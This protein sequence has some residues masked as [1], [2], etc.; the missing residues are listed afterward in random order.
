MTKPIK[1]TA[2]STCDLSAPLLRK[3][4]ISIAPLHI[5][6]G[7]RTYRD[8]VD[9]VPGDLY[10][11]VKGTG[12]LPKTSA[13]TVAD[14]LD[15]FRPFTES[16][17]A[18]IHFTISRTMSSCYQNAVLAGRETGNVFV[19]DS[20]NL[21]TGIG[22]LALRAA[23]LARTG[24]GAEAIVRAA[25]RLIPKVESSFIIDT[26]RYLYKGGRCSSVAA[27]GANLLSLKP[28]I[29]VRG[30][31]MAVGKKYR[32]SLEKCLVSYVTDRLKGRADLDLSRIFITHSAMPDGLCEKAARL[33]KTLAPFREVLDTSAGGTI[34]SHCGPG[35]LGVLFLRK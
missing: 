24:W 29:E 8:G 1:I 32:G 19:V 15:F 25:G 28:C 6:L 34:C 33:V 20:R 10:R 23:E 14:Y 4:D 11:Y 21:S 27:L 3:Y 30:G 18:V 16:G 31:A 5:N 35:T 2:D 26:L 12:R 13:V 7:G 17:K 22:L 9:L